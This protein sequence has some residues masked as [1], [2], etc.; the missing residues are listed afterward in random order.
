MASKRKRLPARTKKT[1]QRRA[2]VVESAER[3]VAVT[4]FRVYRDQLLTLKRLA[5][6]RTA[7]GGGRLDASA[8]LRDLLDREF[9]R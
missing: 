4:T 6:D 8:V 9:D 5:L 1:G 3:P 7:A 2:E